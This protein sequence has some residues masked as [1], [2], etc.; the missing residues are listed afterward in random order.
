MYLHSVLLCRQQ[1]QRERQRESVCVCGGG[2]GE[3]D[4]YLFTPGRISPEV[5]DESQM[6][7]GGEVGV[8]V[9]V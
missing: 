7:R 1:R 3:L 6:G 5:D 2:G 4:L 8:W 9:E